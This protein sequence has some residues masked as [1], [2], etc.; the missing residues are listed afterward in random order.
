MVI[1]VIFLIVAAWGFYIGF[2]RGII[3]TVF[4]LASIVFGIIAAFRFAHAAEDFLRTAISD[5][6]PLL[7]PAGWLL[8]FVL[9]MIIIRLIANALEGLLES[10][11]INIINKFAGGVLFGSLLIL[12]YSMILW[13]GNKSH[14]LTVSSTQQSFT[15]PYLREFPGQMRTVYDALAPGFRDSWDRAMEAMDR[16]DED[17]N[18]HRNESEP[19]IYDIPDEGE[20][21]PN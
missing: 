19:A 10:A 1:D 9:T 12:M 8:V 20:G 3:Q 6:S 4:T 5:E 17:I 15:Y 21:T 13:F 2:S 11:N 7:Y 18:V 14:V 16:L